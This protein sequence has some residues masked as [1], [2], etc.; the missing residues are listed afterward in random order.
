MYMKYANVVANYK[1]L[2]CIF[3]TNV[4]AIAMKKLLTL[5]AL[6]L[7][8]IALYWYFANSSTSAT[9]Q[10]NPNPSHIHADLKILIRG[11]PLQIRDFEQYVLHSEEPGTTVLQRMRPFKPLWAEPCLALQNTSYC[12]TSSE[13]WKMYVNGN[14]VPFNTE[15]VF[16]DLDIIVLTFGT[17]QTVVNE[18]LA[19]FKDKA[20]MYSQTCPG[21]G[22]APTEEC[23]AASGN[24]CVLQ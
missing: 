15:Y 16:K 9:A 23:V 17:D 19:T 12:P 13:Q 1:E 11:E 24:P 18:T 6:I 7:V 14:E 21:R 20:C 8:A 2:R 5:L 10:P 4:Y 22:D 3:L